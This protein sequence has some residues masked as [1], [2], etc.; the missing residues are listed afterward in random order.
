M[1]SLSIALVIIGAMALYYG[2]VR[3]KPIKIDLSEKRL[4]DLEERV[5]VLMLKNGFKP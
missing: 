2:L 4:A 3:L 5:K 1:I